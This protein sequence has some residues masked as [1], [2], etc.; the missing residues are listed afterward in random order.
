ME[1]EFFQPKAKPTMR[2]YRHQIRGQIDRPPKNRVMPQLRRLNRP[3]LP[4]IRGPKSNTKIES[5]IHNKQT[6][7]QMA[8]IWEEEFCSPEKRNRT[9]KCRKRT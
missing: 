7:T 5:S 3:K 1:E 6:C 8:N 2:A 9:H 4:R